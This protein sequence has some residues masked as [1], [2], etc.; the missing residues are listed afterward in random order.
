M[1]TVVQRTYRPQIAP[2]V[3]GLV[4]NEIDAAI[5]SKNVDTVAGIGFG[6]AVSQGTTQDGIIIGG[7]AFVGVTVRDVTQGLAPLDPL[8]DVVGTVDTYGRYESAGVLSRGDIWVAA[9]VVVAAGDPASYNTTTGQLATGTTGIS[10]T[11]TLTFTQQPAANSTIVIA[12]H[13]ITFK[14]SGAVAANDEVNIGPTLGDTLSRVAALVAAN[15]STNWATVK[16]IAYPPS[17][18]GAAQ[19]SGANELHVAAVTAG[20]AG[21]AITLTAGTAAGVTASGA[22]L[23][24]GLAGATAI[25]GGRWTTSAQAGELAIL[26]LGIQA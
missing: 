15:V 8:S 21:N 2:A 11:G 9:G 17:P 23:L 25:S 10:A 16:V 1:S 5:K 19:G 12:A 4:A 14:A 3:V 26:S 6:L 24:G 22:T 18:G 13:N 20:V 7:S